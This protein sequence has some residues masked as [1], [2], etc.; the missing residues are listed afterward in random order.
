MPINPCLIIVRGG[1]DLGTGVIYRL[2]KSGFPVIALELAHP[3]VVRRRVALA[4]AVLED[5]VL[6]EDLHRTAG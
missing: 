4:T 5:E 3:L 2:H 6:I 1:G